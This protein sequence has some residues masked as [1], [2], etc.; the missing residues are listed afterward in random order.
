M[1]KTRHLCRNCGEHA[2][3][4]IRRDPADVD[5]VVHLCLNCVDSEEVFLPITQ[6]DCGL[7]Y[8]AIM[9]VV[10][11]LTLVISVFA[12]FLAFGSSGGFGFKQIA[13]VALG[14]LFL[15][16]GIII[17]IRT[18]VVIG[19][20]TGILTLLADWLGFGSAEGFGG[21]QILGVIVGLALLSAGFVTGFKKE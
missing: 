14:A 20:I 9:V 12:D 11:F 17:R 16:A 3:V 13:G 4:H 15:T 19:L 6:Q 18:L 7:D 8:A 21:Q 10:G 2:I 5:S 1:K